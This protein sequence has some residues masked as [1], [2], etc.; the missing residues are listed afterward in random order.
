MLGTRNLNYLSFAN[1]TCC[2]L[3]LMWKGFEI[4]KGKL[5]FYKVQ[6]T[7]QV[8]SVLK[9]ASGTINNSRLS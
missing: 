5:L 1:K 2:Q 3:T 6:L 9:F 7:K 8:D 4:A